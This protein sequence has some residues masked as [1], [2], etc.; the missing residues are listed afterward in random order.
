VKFA[1]GLKD[2]QGKARTG[3]VGVTF[4]VYKDQ[5]GGAAL[6]LETQNVELDEQGHYTVLLGAT[7]NEGLPLELFSA[8]EPRWLGMQVNLSREVEQPRVLLVSVP[9][10]LKAADADTLGGKPLSSFV[11]TNAAGGSSSGTVLIPSGPIVSQ[12]GGSGSQ[13]FLAKFDSTGTNVIN[14]SIFDT[15]TNV[16]IGTSSPARTLHVKSAAPVIRLEDSALPN[17][18]W[19]LQQSAFVTD[20]FGFLRY[21]SGSAVEGK[22][23]VVS[24]AGNMGIGTGQPQRKL[25]IKSA[26][27]V[28][29]LEDTNLPN[30]FWELQQSAFVLD[31]FGFLRYENGAVVAAKSFVMS[32]GGNFGIGTGTPSQKLEVAGNAKISGAGNALIFPDG[33]VLSSAATG[34]GGGTITGVTAGAGLSGGGTTG[35]VT[36][37]VANSGITNAMLSANSVTNANIAVGS[38]NPAIITGT[39]ATLGTN[40]FVGDQSITGNLNVINGAIVAPGGVNTANTGILLVGASSFIH[41]FGVQNT[42]VGQGAGNFTQTVDF[43]SNSG[44]GSFNTGVG[45]STL[46][47]V[48]AAR[49]NSAFGTLALFSDTTGNGNAA[50]GSEA[51]FSNTT[52]GFNSAFGNFALNLNTT[53]GSNSAF[54]S[55]AL[56]SNTTGNNNS[57]LGNN[58][59]FFATGNNNSA[60]GNFALTHLTT[61]N[62]DIAIGN[63]AGF[64]LTGSESNDIYIGN[65]GV[66]GESNTIRIG[67]GSTQTAAFI[68]GISGVNVSG[69]AVMVNGSG[70]LGVVVSSR[71]FKHEIAD[72]GTESDLLMKLRP[73]AFYY[74]PELDETQTRQY[75]LV[76]EEVAQVAPELVVYD[77]DG[78]VQTVRYH[79]VNAMLLN[80]VQKQRHTIEQQQAEIEALTAR[81]AKLEAAAT[82]RP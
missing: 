50:F 43:N 52:A 81:L 28:I 70:Q 76:A 46:S 53:G 61:G 59:L 78:Q 13:N 33:S 74:K 15:G 4:A 42:Y 67:D 39:A 66:A 58:A 35:G 56:F 73:V 37:N 29:R 51:L 41:N 31:T 44:N 38:L 3:V 18:F 72:M 12:V 62:S 79:F 69:S 8:G 6:W 57:A 25:H 9:Y 7:R 16:G 36:L 17:S 19:E 11:M 47:S 71:R 63:N 45:A 30:S 24:S 82:S 1:G 55:G 26:T 77:K 2:E 27:P 60:L 64:N 23:F 34:V 80:E 49:G 65:T 20:T 22:S 10:A 40:A 75:G 5:E 14:S 54:G 32:S 48:T 21:E 68:T